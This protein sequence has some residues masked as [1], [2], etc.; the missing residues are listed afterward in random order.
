M[1]QGKELNGPWCMMYSRKIIEREHIRFDKELK[2]GEDTI[3]TNEY[4]ALAEHVV[5]VNKTL[6]YL[7]NNDDSA[8][9]TYNRDVQ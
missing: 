7:H 3:F 6:Y 4:L 8:I 1:R 9:D 5:T 2:I